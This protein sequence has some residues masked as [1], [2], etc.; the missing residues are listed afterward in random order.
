MA[1]WAAALKITPAA[2]SEGNPNSKPSSTA[3]TAAE[4]AKKKAAGQLG[5]E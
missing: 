1:K 5:A 3:G 2:G 4:K